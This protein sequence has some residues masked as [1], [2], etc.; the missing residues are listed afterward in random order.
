M[1]MKTAKH[2]TRLN[3]AKVEEAVKALQGVLIDVKSIP[4]DVK[5]ARKKYGKNLI[6]IHWQY[7]DVAFNH[8][9][10][11]HVCTW[12]DGDEGFILLKPNEKQSSVS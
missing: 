2:R 1:Q 10:L 11:K 7:A 3:V 8:P 12:S 9:G 6:R 4:T 5:Q